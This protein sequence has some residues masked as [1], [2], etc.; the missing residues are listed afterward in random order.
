VSTYEWLAAYQRAEAEQDMSK[1]HDCVLTVENELFIRMQ[2]LSASPGVEA[3]TELQEIRVAA[4]GLLRIKTE[5][6]KWPGLD[7]GERLNNSS[8]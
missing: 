7:L 5:K 3:Q 6:L 4:R 8:N 1:L 2:E